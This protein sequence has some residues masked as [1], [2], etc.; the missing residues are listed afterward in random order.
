MNL[1]TTV[2]NYFGY[3]N[4]QKYYVHL[5]HT[6]VIYVLNY[7]FIFYSKYLFFKVL[8]PV[9][10]TRILELKDTAKKE[11]NLVRKVR[12]AE[13]QVHADRLVSHSLAVKEELS[14]LDDQMKEVGRNQQSVL[15]EFN[16]R[17]GDLESENEKPL[18]TQRFVLQNQWQ[19]IAEQ[20]EESI[21]Q[22]KAHFEA[23]I[24]DLNRANNSFSTTAKSFKSG[25]NY[26]PEEVK[27]LKKQLTTLSKSIATQKKILTNKYNKMLNNVKSPVL[28]SKMNL[29]EEELTKFSFKT[30][31]SDNLS[32]LRMRLRSEI[33]IMKNKNQD[34]ENDLH[35]LK[36][37][38]KIDSSL[39]KDVVVKIDLIVN[40]MKFPENIQNLECTKDKQDSIQ[41]VETNV[42]KKSPKSTKKTD[43]SPPLKLTPLLRYA[44]KLDNALQAHNNFFAKT[45]DIILRKYEILVNLIENSLKTQTRMSKSPSKK[46]NIVDDASRNEL[47]QQL[48]MLK[49]IFRSY[50]SECETAW[51]VECKRFLELIKQLR[52][53]SNEFAN[54]VLNCVHDK[55]MTELN[56]VGNAF[57]PKRESFYRAEESKRNKKHFPLVLAHPNHEG[58]LHDW[59]KSVSYTCTEAISNFKD[60]LQQYTQS[61]QNMH[62]TY[63]SK[64]KVLKDHFNMV[65]NLVF[66]SE[67]CKPLQENLS[68][69]SLFKPYKPSDE[70]IQE[71]YE[72]IPL[73]I[74]SDVDLSRNKETPSRRNVE[75]TRSLDISSSLMST[76]DVDIEVTKT[77]IDWRAI[78]MIKESG[79]IANKFFIDEA[80]YFKRF[81]A[82]T[83]EWFESLQTEIKQCQKLY[84]IEDVEKSILKK[85]CQ[86]Q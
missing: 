22:A 31:I 40:Y 32:I 34:F 19:S 28:E 56:S 84:N 82:E 38:R 81:E 11:V 14:T 37:L 3:F 50:N 69:I 26:S 86:N 27:A 49:M 2:L 42:S 59:K 30:E 71:A 18:R 20:L 65:Q 48:K 70:D 16:D 8:V 10:D 68:K 1:F 9:Y 23:K 60:M 39:L 35:C 29:I 52:D 67:I 24:E 5:L 46:K 79:L 61:L 33:E 15:R 6:F 25:G 63:V 4:K 74:W 53:N 58:K 77:P 7:I 57:Q 62:D 17:I 78:D 55:Y 80:T 45:K 75:T 73:S 43:K 41:S 66:D 72:M 47:L 64:V 12:F 54:T 76:L 13:L 36:K 83:T 85:Y 21:R 44:N 51:L